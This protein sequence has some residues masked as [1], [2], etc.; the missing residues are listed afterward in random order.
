[1]SDWFDWFGAFLIGTI[2]L[3][4]VFLL[5]VLVGAGFF[6]VKC[7]QSGDPDS[8]AC[9]MANGNTQRIKADVRLK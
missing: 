1:M 5:A 6:A 3:L 7:Y 8:M 4:M 9:Y 2:A